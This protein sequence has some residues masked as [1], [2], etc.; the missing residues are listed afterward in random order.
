[1]QTI[2]VCVLMKQNRIKNTMLLLSINLL[3]DIDYTVCE[4][5]KSNFFFRT[6]KE[7]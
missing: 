6:Q 3:H 1:M 7:M 5:G 2:V 4:S